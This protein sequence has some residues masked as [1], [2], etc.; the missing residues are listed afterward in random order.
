[1][2]SVTAAASPDQNTYSGSAANKPRISH[3]ESTVKCS[4]FGA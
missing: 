1:M 2:G 3:Q 4:A